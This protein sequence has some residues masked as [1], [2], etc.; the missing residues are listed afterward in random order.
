MGDTWYHGIMR[1]PLNGRR[2]VRGDRDTHAAYGVGPATDYGA[3]EGEPVFAMCAGV[4]RRYSSETGGNSIRLDDGGRLVV[5][6]QHFVDYDGGL[7]G[8]VAEGDVIARVG[9]TGTM[10]SG[11]H[12]HG[13]AEVD[14]SRM[15][16]EELFR[17]YFPDLAFT[18]LGSYTPG[19]VRAGI[20]GIIA[21]PETG[22]TDMKVIAVEASS[23]GL[24]GGDGDPVVFT[25]YTTQGF[26]IEALVQ[27]FGKSM[28]TPDQW[29]TLINFQ[30]A[31]AAVSAAPPFDL[32][33]AIAGIVDG[34]AAAG[35]D[36]ASPAQ[37]AAAVARALDVPFEE[38]PQSVRDS[39]GGP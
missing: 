34:L 39:V 30:K 5:Y 16:I 18:S 3:D 32:D 6:L 12:L 36:A 1:R 38:L 26:L 21:R 17:D 4:V 33:K 23:I 8:N 24:V 11:P 14:G 35:L 7:D 28:V 29:I 25:D 31:K 10:S 9:S 20:A 2:Y 19:R 15:S 37:N 13:W 27:V 22:E